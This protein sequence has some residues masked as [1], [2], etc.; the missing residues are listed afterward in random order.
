MDIIKSGKMILLRPRD[1]KLPQDPHLWL[2]L[3]DLPKPNGLVVAVMVCTQTKFTDTTLILKEGDH[4]F[5]RHDT[6]V[7]YTSARYLQV[8]YIIRE[9]GLGRC[10]LRP[11]MSKELLKRVQ[12][13]LIE[14]PSTVTAIRDYCEKCFKST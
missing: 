1:N 13:G 14:S 10:H 6:S 9:M 5:I 3:T 8:F 2:V 4:P 11:D 12:K 7:Q